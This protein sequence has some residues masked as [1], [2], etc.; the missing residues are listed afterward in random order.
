[1]LIAAQAV[2]LLHLV[3]VLFAVL[4]SALVYWRWRIAWLHLPALAWGVWIELTHGLCPLTT[5][6]NHLLREADAPGYGGGFIEHYL[7]PL[8]YPPG[9]QPSHQVW[10]AAAL[11]GIN[12]VGYG[13]AIRKHCYRGNR[14][15]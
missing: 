15:A 12:L 7:M 4:G 9:L 10:L 11:L 13:L 2:L 3:F 8:L 5:L 14:R 1:M 6:E